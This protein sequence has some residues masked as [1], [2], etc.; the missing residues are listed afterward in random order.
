MT[1]P[2]SGSAPNG[3]ASP[4]DP[5]WT[6]SE[7]RIARKAFDAALKRELDEVIQ[8]AKKMADRIEQPSELWDL[9]DYLTRRR[10]AINQKYDSRGSRLTH[11]LGK[12]LYEGRLEEEQLRGLSPD[13]LK[14]I[15]SYKDFLAE[16]E[17][18]EPGT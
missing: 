4:S 16:V 13:K 2:S 11:V 8:E 5:L 6:R 15:R 9:E 18:A 7:K 3:R 12:L 1:N 10:K 17:A 14:A